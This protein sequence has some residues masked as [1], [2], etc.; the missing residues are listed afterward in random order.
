M[1]VTRSE[2]IRCTREDK[3]LSD[4]QKEGLIYLLNTHP[5][6]YP[7]VYRW[8]RVLSLFVSDSFDGSLF[9][10]KLKILHTLLEV[11]RERR[12]DHVLWELL[13]IF[14]G[15]EGTLLDSGRIIP[16]P[17]IDQVL[18]RSRKEERR[19][20]REKWLELLICCGSEPP[21][22]S[23]LGDYIPGLHHP[24]EMFRC[25][26]LRL[27]YRH[28]G[29]TALSV[30]LNET[31]KIKPPPTPLF[32]GTLCHFLRL[33]PGGDWTKDIE[34]LVRQR[35]E[36][37]SDHGKRDGL[38][39]LLQEVRA[40]L[41]RNQVLTMHTPL[42]SFPEEEVGK[43]R[44]SSRESRVERDKGGPYS[45]NRMTGLRLERFEKIERD[46]GRQE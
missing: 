28:F 27:L 41:T 26:V 36:T 44:R 14:Y 42:S 8:I 7:A 22:G 45:S 39:I 20:L 33:H 31:P 18:E 46:I 37:P 10:E 1:S 19:S 40:F 15:K 29:A 5:S 32:Y 21:P 43:E 3:A 12:P 4:H 6:T 11:L 2:A 16:F 38:W 25:K 34:R 9:S 30:V 35:G 13:S 17:F 24:D 23:A